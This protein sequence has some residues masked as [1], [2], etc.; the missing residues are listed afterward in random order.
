MLAKRR[1]TNWIS[2][3]QMYNG[4]LVGIFD[5]FLKYPASE[6]KWVIFS[7]KQPYLVLELRKSEIEGTHL[8]SLT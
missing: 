5:K 4:Y 1:P 3:K 7:L 8:N 2:Y 6:I